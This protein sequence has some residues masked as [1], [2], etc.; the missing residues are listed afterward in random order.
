MTAPTTLS[1]EDV[2]GKTWIT[3]VLLLISLLVR[4]LRYGESLGLAA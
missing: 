1:G 4:S 2:E 3:L